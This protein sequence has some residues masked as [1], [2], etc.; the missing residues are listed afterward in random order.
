MSIDPLRLVSSHPWQR[1]A[2]T[3]YALSLS[4]FEA[5][6]LDALLRGGANAQAVI[7]AD[8]MGVRE[9]LSEQG[10]HRVGRDYEVEPVAVTGGVFHPKISVLASDDE[11]HLLVGSGNLTFNGWG[12]NCEILEHLHPAFAA[13]AI[14]DAGDFFELLAVTDRVRFG[15][16]EHCAATAAVLRR[17]VQGR[18]GDGTIRLLHSLDRSIAEQVA[19]VAADMGGAQRLVVAA[20]F[21]DS[22]AALDNLCRALGLQE[23]LVHAHTKGCVEGT[24]G[25]NWP[26]NATVPVR[27]VRV[28]AMDGPAEAKRPLHA[29]ALEI[30]C[31]RGRVLVSGSANGTRAALGSNGNV[32]ACVMRVQ[33]ERSVGWTVAQAETPDPQG[34]VDGAG[35]ESEFVRAGVLR[36]VLEG[37]DVVG[38]V[39]TPSMSGAVRVCHMAAVGPELL[40]ETALDDTA[41]FKFA[42]PDLEKSSW[43]GGRLVIRVTDARGRIAEGFASIASFAEVTRRGGIVTRRLF[44]IIFGNETPEDVTA[45]LSWFFEDPRR[46]SS[47]PQEIRSGGDSKRSDDSDQLVPLAALHPELT[48]GI[49]AATPAGTGE[50]HW[51]RFLDSVLAAFR[52][53]RGP[54]AGTGSGATGEDEDDTPREGTKAETKD[55][56]ID[57]AHGSFRQLFDVLTKDGSPPRNC[58]VAFDL[59]GFICAR[60]RPD[61][62]EVRG[63][64][65]RVIRVW[66][67]AGVRAE[68]RDDVAS[69]VLTVLGT[70]P[71]AGRFRWARGCLLRLG[72]DFSASPPSTDAVRNYQTVLLQLEEAEVLWTRLQMIRTFKEQVAAC[73]R[74][75][76]RG[77]PTFE[78]YPDLPTEAPEAWLILTEAFRSPTAKSNLLFSNTA[79]DTCPVHHISLPKREVHRLR[80][81]GIAMTKNCCRRVLISREH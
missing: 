35:D 80:T 74:A 48:G 18:T 50:R 47:D 66:L 44:S 71:E 51:S 52:E 63:W 70:A 65:E 20:P 29:K 31:R 57:R 69:A 73:L 60:L 72:L 33:R 77:H 38:Q 42:A 22:G 5:V 64:L 37:D 15:A 59:T 40:A 78:D 6:V 56:A 34:T 76:E 43:R 81:I 62:Q 68:R 61:L 55:P 79:N 67:A 75:I 28:A 41:S 26:R 54:F 46:L 7:L 4:F 1:A 10:A 3:T 14:A 32:E 13:D 25:A 27:A 19:Q 11:C 45:V 58:E 21:W 17:A 49:A 30:L 23:V 9:S 36:A 53:S 8:V 24:V 16:G 12:G 39:L 2:F